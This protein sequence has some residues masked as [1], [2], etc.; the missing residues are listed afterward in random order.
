MNSFPGLEHFSDVKL[1]HFCLL[2]IQFEICDASGRNMTAR[3][4]DGPTK[5]S[6]YFFDGKKLILAL[7]YKTLFYL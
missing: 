2:L 7:F 5:N 1:L 3:Y 6:N 4:V